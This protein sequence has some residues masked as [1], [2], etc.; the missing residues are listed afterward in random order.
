MIDNL[1][2]WKQHD[3]LKTETEERYAHLNRVLDIAIEGVEN[4][5]RLLENDE[6]AEGYELLED[7]IMRL[8]GER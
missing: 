3:R 2:L 5:L 6:V 8:E 1:G 4:A 7:L